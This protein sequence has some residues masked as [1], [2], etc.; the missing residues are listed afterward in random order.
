MFRLLNCSI[1]LTTCLLTNF[2]MS[3]PLQAKPTVDSTVEQL[4]NRF[5][6]PAFTE[7][8]FVDST[9]NKSCQQYD[10]ETRLCGKGDQLSV[11]Q[12]SDATKI[13]KPGILFL[14]RQGDYQQ[15]L[16][17]SMSGNEKAYIGFSAYQNEQ[18]RIKGV[19]SIDQ[20][21]AYGAIWLDEASYI[22]ING[23]TVT[24]SIGFGRFLNAHHNIFSNNNFTGST[25]YNDGENASKRGG[26]YIAFSHHNQIIDN[27]FQKGTDLL[28]LVHSNY[29]RVEG[30]IM[31]LAGH[32]IWNIKCGSFNV[33]RNNVFSNKKQKL[34]AVFDCE[35]G[36]MDW[37]GNGRFKQ[38]APVLDASQYNLIEHNIFKDAVRYYSTSGGNGIQ[39]AGQHGIIRFNTFYHTNVGFSLASY[40]TEAA[41]TYSNRIY[42]NTFHDNWCVGIAVGR[43]IE[44]FEDNQFVNNILW[45]N[46]GVGASQCN[47]QNATQIL[48]SRKEGDQ[49]FV[50]NNIA[51]DKSDQV[52]GLWGVA[53][54]MSVYDFEGSFIPVQFKDTLAKDPLFVD[55][56]K[57]NYQLSA[58]SPMIDAGVM[59]SNIISDSGKGLHV[60]VQDSQFFY[61]GAG[62]EGEPGDQIMILSAE[63]KSLQ[64]ATIVHI[65]R[66]LNLLTLNK[67][68]S[69]QKGDMISLPY[70]GTQPDLGAFEFVKKLQ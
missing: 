70:Q 24:D 23:I 29:N 25:I 15:A 7:T 67:I 45:N 14:I 43:W 49:W 21:Q 28:S 3:T 52:I 62:I 56:T 17:V 47:T 13:A 39:Y 51:S 46:Q 40:R 61:D 59:L 69:W 64:S 22:A 53:N 20:R 54:K 32:D 42:N 8:I 1:L 9:L 41:Y 4:I 60:K 48:F 2:L 10:P 33:I 63:N 37:H 5:N 30:N 19:D 16:H 50:R 34:G 6:L 55:Q 38:P 26:L 36:T 57:H 68:V 18:V 35:E 11:S 58:N 65:D 66:K 44:K 31:T 12:L 27:R